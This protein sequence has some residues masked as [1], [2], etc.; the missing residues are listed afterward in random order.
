MKGTSPCPCPTYQSGRSFMLS[1]QEF[2][3]G[4]PYRYV[5]SS[6][7]SL[8]KT[9][10]FIFKK[11][12]AN[13]PELFSCAVCNSALNGLTT[14][15]LLRDSQEC[16]LLPRLSISHPWCHMLRRRP[17]LSWPGLTVGTHAHIHLSGCPLSWSF[18]PEL[19][20]L[21]PADHTE[22]SVSRNVV[23]MESGPTCEHDVPGLHVNVAWRG[24]TEAG[25]KFFGSVLR[26]TK[27]FVS[28][29][30]SCS[31][32]LNFVCHTHVT[33]LSVVNS[34]FTWPWNSILRFLIAL[35]SS[36]VRGCFCDE[37][38]LGWPLWARKGP[39][40]F[41]CWLW[42]VLWWLKSLEAAGLPLKVT[43][44]IRLMS[45]LLFLIS[46]S[47]LL[48]VWIILCQE[49]TQPSPWCDSCSNSKPRAKALCSSLSSLFTGTWSLVTERTVSVTCMQ[50]NCPQGCFVTSVRLHGRHQDSRMTLPSL[51]P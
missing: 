48:W 30:F 36:Q 28:G 26:V 16:P 24:S 32:C 31:F 51:V 22:L 4:T 42:C 12:I 6:H 15:L 41:L 44:Q 40:E 27:A 43:R 14:H 8:V 47:L 35:L 3:S 46:Q 50:G 7:S 20:R 2:L 34:R 45:S 39:Q 25:L 9:L 37:A 49:R 1:F 17:G 10:D 11:P 5:P 33:Y 21:S 38:V 13:L 23:S 19:P 29:F 18:L